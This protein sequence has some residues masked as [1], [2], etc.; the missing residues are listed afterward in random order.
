MARLI[1]PPAEGRSVRLTAGQS[2]TITTPN[3]AQAADFFAFNS[4]NIE[5]WL[6]ANHSWVFTRHVRPRAGDT[7]LSRFRRP[8]LEF[9]EDGA[10]GTHDMMIAA[11]DQFRYEQFGYRGN[12]ASCS[13]NLEVSMRRLGLQVHVIP[14]PLNFFTRTE[15]LNDGTLISPP[16][17]VPPGAYVKLRALMDLIC[18][19]SSC[20]FDL[21]V[22][23]WTINAASGPSELVVEWPGS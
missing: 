21:S 7:F 1:V 19:V 17:P 4:S 22:E 11:C 10:G 14:Q 12:H 9:V 2:L 16:N 15:V 13:A 18:V 5:E 20:P 23:G 6:S 3:G 8:M